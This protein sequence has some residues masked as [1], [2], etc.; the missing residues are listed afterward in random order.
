[1]APTQESTSDT[2]EQPNP[3]AK[4]TGI[5]SCHEGEL[6]SQDGLTQVS[7]GY[8]RT[9][10]GLPEKHNKAY[11]AAKQAAP[12]PRPETPIDMPTNN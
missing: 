5:V 8:F 2:T 10:S 3:T 4:R 6:S 12:A 7:F 11:P 9:T 1:M